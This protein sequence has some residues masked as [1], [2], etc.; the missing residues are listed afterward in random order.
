M[1]ITRLVALCLVLAFL[2]ALTA[3]CGSGDDV[4]DFPEVVTLGEGDLFPSIINGPLAVGENRIVMQLLD[5]DDNLLLD[6]ELHLRFYNLNGDKPRLAG[7]SDARLISSELSFID[8]NNSFRRT[9]TGEGGAYVAYATFDQPGAWGAEF[10]ILRAGD[11]T[12]V[13]YR[14]N[15]LEDSV[16]PGLGDPAPASVQATT[17]TEPIEEIDSS[18]PFREAMHTTTV[19]DALKTGKPIVIAFATPAF[20]T[21]RTCGPVLDL[22]VDPLFWRYGSDAVFIHIEP[23]S[24]RDLRAANVQNAVPAVLEWR[25]Q[26]EPWIFV[27]GRDGRIAGKFEGLVAMDEVESVLQLLL[28]EGPASATPAATGTP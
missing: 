27:V 20:C 13:P 16:E 26:S 14:F 17:A 18:F 8:E 19:A 9:V 3:A 10:T 24:L 4:P 12:V 22:V 11:E 2:P 25:L 15:V 1:R 23:Y 28:A 21:S 7:E 6:A 5:A